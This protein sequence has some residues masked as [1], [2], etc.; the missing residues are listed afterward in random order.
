METSWTLKATGCHTTTPPG[1]TV[2]SA[3]VGRGRSPP[4]LHC[5][6]SSHLPQHGKSHD[7][8]SQRRAWCHLPADT[9]WQQCFVSLCTINAFS[10]PC[11]SPSVSV[12]KV[13]DYVLF[14]LQVGKGYASALLNTRRTK[15]LLSFIEHVLW[16]AQFLFSLYLILKATCKIGIFLHFFFFFFFFT[17]ADPMELEPWSIWHQS[18]FILSSTPSKRTKASLLFSSNIPITL[19]R[20]LIWTSDYSHKAK[21]KGPRSKSCK[22]LELLS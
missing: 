3:R 15:Q 18:P 6:P 14:R 1:K 17:E 8:T 2:P 12:M 7:V 20:K 13:A 11:P 5:T 22:G 16:T 19:T 9:S 21:L 4:R 10:D